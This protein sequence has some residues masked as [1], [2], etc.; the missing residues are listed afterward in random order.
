MKNFNGIILYLL[1]TINL[2]KTEKT[3]KELIST[4]E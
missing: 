2:K 3:E 4:N 1:P